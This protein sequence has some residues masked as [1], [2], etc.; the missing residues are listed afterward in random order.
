M[1]RIILTAAP[2]FLVDMD[3]KETKHD[4]KS[5]RIFTKEGMNR[6]CVTAWEVEI[7]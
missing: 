6:G 4:Q 7:L 5:S 3:K 1:T 2:A